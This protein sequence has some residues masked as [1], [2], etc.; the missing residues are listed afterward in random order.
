MVE[1]TNSGL[2][3]TASLDGLIRLW[4]LNNLRLMT[5]LEDLEAKKTGAKAGEQKKENLRCISGVRAVSYCAEYGGFLVSSGFSNYI[6]V[7]TPDS[8][9][10]KAFAG[11]LEG[12]TGIVVSCRIFP[13]SPHCVSVDDKFSVRLWDLRTQTCIQTIR[14]EA[15]VSSANGQAQLAPSE[16]SRGV[17][18]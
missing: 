13:G 4:T 1:V 7:W 3:A 15:C 11:K 18:W 16:L 14:N 9:L 10:S 17:P 6:N 2:L 12:H 5:E 8:S